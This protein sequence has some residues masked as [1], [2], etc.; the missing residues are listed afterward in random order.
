MTILPF[1]FWFLFERLL[2]EFNEPLIGVHGVRHLEVESLN[3]LTG[4][5]MGRKSTFFAAW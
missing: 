2:P 5:S 3:G 1:L 4:G